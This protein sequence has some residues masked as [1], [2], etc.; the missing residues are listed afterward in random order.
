MSL[1]YRPHTAL[2]QTASQKVT[3][4]NVGGRNLASAVSVQ[5]QIT[6]AKATLVYEQFNI[7]LEAPFMLMCDLE[8]A[9]HFKTGAVVTWDSKT[10][11]V[12]A[13]E[14]WSAIP[15]ISFVSVIL[16]ETKPA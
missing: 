2:V 8:D 3:S 5:C 6:P 13:S 1:A 9:E 4:N 16:K 15:A 14:P 10:F 12:M 7:Q 11:T